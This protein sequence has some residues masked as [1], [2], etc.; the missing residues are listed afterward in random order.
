M[1]NYIIIN[2]A[3]DPAQINNIANY[4]LYMNAVRI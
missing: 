3:W 4:M 2:C 1:N